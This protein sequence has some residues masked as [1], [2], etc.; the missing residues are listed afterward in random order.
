MAKAADH[1]HLKSTN[2]A[3]SIFDKA[4]SACFLSFYHYISIGYTL[5]IRRLTLIFTT[6]YSCRLSSIHQPSHSKRLIA[7]YGFT[8]F[9]RKFLIQKSN[10]KGRLDGKN[11]KRG[12]TMGAPINLI[13][14]YILCPV[15]RARSRCG[16]A[17]PLRQLIVF[18]ILMRRK[19][20][21]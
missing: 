3:I 9:T 18:H 11:A 12:T 14:I 5:I 17:V 7:A 1:R 4:I 15:S 21:K 16:C 2:A 10:G 8:F 20:E 6:P 13:H 19:R